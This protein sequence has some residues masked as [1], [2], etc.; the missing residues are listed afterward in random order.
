M[1]LNLSN[2]QLKINY[3][4]VGCLYVDLMVTTVQNPVIDAPKIKRKEYKHNTK[5]NHQV[6]REKRMRRRNREEQHE[7]SENNEQ[8]DSKYIAINILNINGLSASIK[9][10]RIAE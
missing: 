1:C 6:R 8:N 2:C 9:R 5:E 4:N 7:Q 10:H 3:C